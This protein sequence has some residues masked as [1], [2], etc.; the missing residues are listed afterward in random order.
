VVHADD[1]V[2]PRLE[3]I[4][5]PTV[6]PLFEPLESPSVEPTPESR[7]QDKTIRLICKKSSGPRPHSCKCNELRIHENAAKI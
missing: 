1:L 4:V 6:P 3:E 7:N 5:L 2:E